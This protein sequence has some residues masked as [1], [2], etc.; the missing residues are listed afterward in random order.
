[1]IKDI[2]KAEPECKV[3]ELCRVFEVSLSSYY[4]KP[5]TDNLATVAVMDLIESISIDSGNT[6]GKRRIHAELIELGHVVGIHKTRTLMKKLNI[7][8][9]R[10]QKRHYYPSSG[11]EHKYAPNVLKRRF[12]PESINTYWVGDITYLKTH[13]G[14]SYLACVLDLA[15][16]EI[17]GYALSQTPDAKLANEALQNAIDREQPNTSQLLFHSDQGVQYSAKIFRDKLAL[18]NMTQSMSRRGNC[19]DNAVMERFF[20]SLK[21]ERLNNITFINHLSVINEVE[22]YIRFYN[23]KRRHSALEYMTPHQKYNKLKKVA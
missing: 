22:S 12:N 11:T 1:M 6:Y 23:Y 15:T 16:K 9:I 7:K 17:V 8:A 21:T 19:W 3:N 10:P 14:W 4:Y 5:I 13:Q 2:K 18:L 20:R